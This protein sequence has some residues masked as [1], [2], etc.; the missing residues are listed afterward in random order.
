MAGPV[1]GIKQL[2]PAAYPRDI[3]VMRPLSQEKERRLVQNIRI[4]VAISLG[5][6]VR[7]GLGFNNCDELGVLTSTGCRKYVITIRP[8]PSSCT[9]PAGKAHVLSCAKTTPIVERIM[10]GYS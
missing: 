3:V 4:I 1:R 10:R 9:P 6:P 8:R 7:E 5:A 2:I